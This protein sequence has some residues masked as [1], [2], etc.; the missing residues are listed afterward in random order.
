MTWKAGNES[1]VR[2]Y[3]FTYDGLNRLLDAVYGE[4]TNIGTNAGRF[5]EKVTSCDKNG[6]ILVLI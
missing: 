2:G 6:N 4:G 3:K 5:T 1:T